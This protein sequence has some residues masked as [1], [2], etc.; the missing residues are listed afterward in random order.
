MRTV[1]GLFSEWHASCNYFEGSKYRRTSHRPRA[2]SILSIA[3]L[4]K[5][6]SCLCTEGV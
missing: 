6:K 2:G 1:Q 3:G 5:G 4:L